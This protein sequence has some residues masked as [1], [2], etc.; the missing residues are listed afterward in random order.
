V[1][2]R[3][4]SLTAAFTVL[5]ALSV[6]TAAVGDSSQDSGKITTIP[7][8]CVTAFSRALDDLRGIFSERNYPQYADFYAFLDASFGD[9]VCQEKGGNLIVD[10]Y[11]RP[12]WRGGGIT[13]VI[14]GD[15]YAIVEVSGSR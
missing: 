2:D 8:N 5:L 7:S 11:P 13:Y 4:N 10:F 1:I 9:T 15:T 6:G 3:R 14:D 12:G